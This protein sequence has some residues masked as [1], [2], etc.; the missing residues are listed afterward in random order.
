MENKKKE[1]TVWDTAGVRNALRRKYPKGEYALIEEVGNATGFKCNRHADVVVMSLWPSRGLTITG[2]EIKAS[3]TDWKKE[4]ESPEKAD[5]IYGYCDYWF[6][7]VG[8]EDIVK[9]G[10]LPATWGLMTPATDGTMRVKIQAEKIEHKPLDRSF[11]AAMLRKAVEQ[12]TP[13][14]D[15][16]LEYERG[17]KEGKDRT[18]K[19]KLYAQN[20]HENLVA[21]VE[22]FEKASGVSI[23]HEWDMENVG[24]AVR[25]VRHGVHLRMQE[26]LGRLK[27]AAE[28]IAKNVD[29][30]M[31]I[32]LENTPKEPSDA[33]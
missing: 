19:T 14:G 21:Q 7:A 24:H 25:M 28:A 22:K 31:T 27:Q 18:E 9:E 17:Y 29:D 13:Q 33:R 15:L 32:L 5:S 8:D 30:H 11:V 6:L 1:R 20:D 3:R 4:L 2:F 16:R 26:Q 23:R 10:E 12:L